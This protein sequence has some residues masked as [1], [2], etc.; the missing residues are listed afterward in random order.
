RSSTSLRPF[1]Q[2]GFLILIAAFM[3]PPADP[4]VINLER[5]II[6]MSMVTLSYAWS[7]LGI[8][9]ASLAR[10]HVIM[11]PDLADVWSGKYV[12]AGPSVILVIFLSIGSAFFLH[13]RAIKGPGQWFYANILAC[14]LLDISMGTAAMFPFPNYDLPKALVVPV[15]F[16]AVIALLTSVLILPQS[17]SAQFTVRLRIVLTSLQAATSQ[18]ATLLATSPTSPDFSPKAAKASVSKVEAALGPLA[19][20]ARLLKLDIVWHRFSGS[21]LE[22]FRERVQRMTVSASGMNLYYHAIS[23]ERPPIS[24]PPSKSTTPSH[25]TPASSGASSPTRCPSPRQ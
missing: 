1:F 4:V 25:V 15:A 6:I 12:E 10:S 18:Q 7:V 20:S 24:D 8:K 2:A 21:D 14:L 17:L 19:M 23:L 13:I 16:H 22:P 11:D 9:L 5:E 3:S